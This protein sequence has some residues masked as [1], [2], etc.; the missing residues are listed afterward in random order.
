M[1]Y[2]MVKTKIDKMGR[3][4]IPSEIRKLFDIKEGDYVEWSIEG[5][6]ITIKKKSETDKEAIKK[7]F[8]AL[9]KKAPVCFVEEKGEEESKWVSKE[10]SLA[11]LGL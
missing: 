9:R 6:N 4:V 8:E 2:K 3:A 5:N 11:K 10:W 7:R 1:G